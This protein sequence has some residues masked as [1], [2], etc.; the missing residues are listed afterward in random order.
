VHRGLAGQSALSFIIQLSNHLINQYQRVRTL[1]EFRT[2][3]VVPYPIQCYR[4]SKWAQIQT[5]KLLP[6]DVVSVGMSLYQ[7][8]FFFSSHLHTSPY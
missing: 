4:E 1:T 5:D 6:G 7:L 2:M 3:S 8:I